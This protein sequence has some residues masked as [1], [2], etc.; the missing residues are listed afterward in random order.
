MNIVFLAGAEDEPFS[1]SD[2]LDLPPTPCP[3]D[4]L[5]LPFIM[6]VL[7]EEEEEEEDI[8]GHNPALLEAQQTFAD[9]LSDAANASTMSANTS[10]AAPAFMASATWPY[11]PARLSQLLLCPDMGGAGEDDSLLA[12]TLFNHG[13]DNKVTMDML[14]QAFLK[15]MEEANKFLPSNNT[16][17]T[18]TSHL[19]RDNTNG[20]ARKNRRSNRDNLEAET[21]RS[22]KLMVPD[23]EEASQMD[24]EFIQNGYQLLLDKMMDMSINMDRE[25]D[26]KKIR[27][28]KGGTNEAVDLRTLLLHCA[29]AVASDD[30]LHATQ[31]LNAIKQRSSPRGDA[32]QRLAHCFAIGLEARLAG[33]GSQVY[34]SLMSRRTPAV[35][36]HKAYYLYLTVCCFQMVAFKFSNMTIVKA[37]AGRKKV[38]IVDYG[39]HSRFQWPILLGCMATWEGGP[40]EV[41]ITGINLPQ[42]GFRPAARI[43]QTGRRLSNYAHRCGIPFKFHSIVAKWET[44]CVDDLNIE[45]DEVLIV[46]GLFHLGNLMD[47]SGDIDSPS[48]RDM[49]LSN[50]QKMR[51][52]VFILC[53]E[54]SSYNAPFF[55]T[56]FREALFY[57]SA[58]FDMMDATTS[59]DNAERTWVE[60]DLLGRCALN[61]IACE[62]WDRLERPE[63]YRQWQVR[64][65]LAGLRQLPLDPNIVSAVSKKVKDGYHKDFFVDVDQQWLLQ[66]WKGRTLYAMS[67]WVANDASS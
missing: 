26:E 55:L 39:D 18:D 31:L 47:E 15:G 51:P 12:S 21:S 65:N 54:N 59:R 46:N 64:N 33:T 44:V 11:D 58:M 66:G 36:F 40:P 53:T 52:D 67:T 34:R 60:Q 49:V 27:K 4:D 35:E 6:R 16:L 19:P 23:S 28:G 17:L 62:G 57:Y 7:M 43:E 63:T 32:T 10:T 3:D 38:H 20:R 1:P 50:I 42:P 2:F 41:K 56:R 29:Q 13:G 61:A 8:N 5:V 22:C 45:P 30:R 25:A 24:E 14:N 48:P 9:I 37:I